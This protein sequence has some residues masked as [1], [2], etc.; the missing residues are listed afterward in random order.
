M[1]LYS[2]LK[3]TIEGNVDYQNPYSE[4]RDNFV[5]KSTVDHIFEIPSEVFSRYCESVLYD[6]LDERLSLVYSAVMLRGKPNRSDYKNYLIAMGTMHM[7][8]MGIKDDKFIIKLSD[9]DILCFLKHVDFYKPY[10]EK[11][12]DDSENIEW[13]YDNSGD[14]GEYI[15]SLL[16]VN[17]PDVL[18]GK[19]SWD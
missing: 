8:T 10:I 11:I 7:P 9:N 6:H 15:I 19:L 1:S 16:N 13:E 4:M 2:G 17:I 5:S 14:E 18:R 12:L 3:N